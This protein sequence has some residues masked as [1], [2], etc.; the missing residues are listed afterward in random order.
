MTFEEARLA[1]IDAAAGTGRIFLI[2]KEHGQC[3]YSEMAR[4]EGLNPK[5]RVLDVVGPDAKTI[6]EAIQIARTVANKLEQP[7]AFSQETDTG[8]WIVCGWSELFNNPKLGMR[9]VDP[10][11]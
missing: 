7:M 11:D 10:G 2:Y 8:L 6:E 9:R 3:V 4:L 1:A 5:P